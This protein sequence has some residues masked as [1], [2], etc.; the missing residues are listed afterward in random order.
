[1]IAFWAILKGL[2]WRAIG[3][4][5][6]VLAVAACGWRVSVWRDAYKAL[7]GVQD[8]LSREEAC[9]DGSRCYERQ[10]GLQEA[11]GHAT[12]VAV[13][14][15][16]AELAELR[17]RPPVRRVIRVCPD[18]GTG[19]LPVPGTARGP[20][21]ATAPAGLVH[22]PAEFDP[23]PLFDLAREADELSARLRALQEYS[24]AVSQSRP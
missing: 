4:I 9:E 10:R 22:G 6:L 23:Q 17:S 5:A 20:D 8:A 11:A 2:P 21:G 18:P 24:R 7:P 13:E 16:E 12:V 1:M 19:H 15:Y 3:A 14:S